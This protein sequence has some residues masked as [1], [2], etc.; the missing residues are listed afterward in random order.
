MIERDTDKTIVCPVCKGTGIMNGHQS[1]C[2]IFQIPSVCVSCNG[3][4]KIECSMP[5]VIIK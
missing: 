3:K 5:N 1:D 2:D 4:G